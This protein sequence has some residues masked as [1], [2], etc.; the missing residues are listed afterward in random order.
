[1]TET[2][3][4]DDKAA[5]TQW[6]TLRVDD[7]K[8]GTNVMQV[9]EVLPMTDIA[10]VPDSPSFVLCII[11]LRDNVVTVIYT[12]M[13]CGLSTCDP[14]DNSRIVMIESGDQTAGMLVD[15]V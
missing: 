10:P 7:V 2:K 12:R 5:V 9:L 11:D 3:S 14:E 6:D 1:M 8:Y 15:S 4:H 13:L